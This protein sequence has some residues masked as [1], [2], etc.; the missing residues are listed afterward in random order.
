MIHLPTKKKKLACI[1]WHKKINTTNICVEPPPGKMGRNKEIQDKAPFCIAHSKIHEIQHSFHLV[2][3][4]SFVSP[5]TKESYWLGTQKQSLS[6][7]DFWQR[8]FILCKM[9][10]A[11]SLYG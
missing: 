4:R 3:K 10:L 1:Q 6:S 2:S 11:Y 5:S 7:P 9:A 8:F